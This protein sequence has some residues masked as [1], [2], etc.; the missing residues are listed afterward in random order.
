MVLGAIWSDGRSQLV[1]CNG[2]FTPV[3][4]ISVL[5][6]GLLPI[7]L[8]HIMIMNESLFMSNGAPCHTAIDAQEWLLQNGIKELR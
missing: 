8:S 7:F 1:E 3:K 5:Q 2:K 4:Y 6:E